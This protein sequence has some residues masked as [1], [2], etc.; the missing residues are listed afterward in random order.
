MQKPI[1][2]KPNF[3]TT[4]IDVLK[5]ISMR[6]GYNLVLH[7]SLTR[8]LDVLVVPW[9]RD[10]KPHIEMIKEFA[11][12]L[13]GWI[14]ERYSKPSYHGRLYVINL[15]RKKFIDANGQSIDPQYYLD[16]S[17]I[18]SERSKMIDNLIQTN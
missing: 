17:V 16:I 1:H 14:D 2:V 18:Q 7:G 8:D 11:T 10:V 5:E 12:Y 6:Y 3:Y 4:C 9:N 13:G 15:N